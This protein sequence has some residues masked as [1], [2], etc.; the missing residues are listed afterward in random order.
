M[1]RKIVGG[2]LLLAAVAIFVFVY[3]RRLPSEIE[4]KGDGIVVYGL[5]L[6]DVVSLGGGIVSMIAGIITLVGAKAKNQKT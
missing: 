3:E 1:M 6:N 4:S 2:F 5:N